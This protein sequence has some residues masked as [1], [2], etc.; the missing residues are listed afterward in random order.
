M[1]R[2]SCGQNYSLMM[3]VQQGLIAKEDPEE[4]QW[5]CLKIWSLLQE[6]NIH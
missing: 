1:R 2:E 6:E 5:Q 4:L 3:T